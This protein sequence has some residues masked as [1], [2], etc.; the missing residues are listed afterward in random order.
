M[1]RVNV[2]MCCVMLLSLNGLQAAN[3]FVSPAG[4]NNNSGSMASPWKTI[5]KGLDIAQPG[6]TIFIRAG[7]YNESVYSQ[8]DGSP[9]ARIVLSSYQ[10]EAVYIDGTGTGANNGVNITHSYYTLQ[11]L[12]IRDW[13][14]TG[15]WIYGNIG[16][17]SVLN[18]RVHDCPYCLSL[19]D[20]THDFVVGGCEMY[21]FGPASG[22]GDGFGFSCEPNGIPCYNGL[23][24][25]CK[26]YHGRSIAANNDGFALGHQDV[27]NITFFK[28]E[29][30]DV[31][32]G[33]DVSGHNILLDRCSAHDITNGDGAYKLWPD[34]ITMVNCIGYHS[35]SIMQ[36]DYDGRNAV[37][38]VYNCTFHDATGGGYN[39]WIENSNTSRLNLFNC[40]VSGGDNRGLVF[41]QNN[42]SNYNGDYNIFQN[43]DTA[44]V[45]STNTIDLSPA[46]IQAGQWT[47]MT[48][49]Q[50]SHSIVLV[51]SASVFINDNGIAPDLHLKSGS[52]AIN[53]GLLSSAP[54][55]DYSGCLRD[56]GFPDIG[57]FEFNCTPSQ[58]LWMPSSSPIR[59]YPNPANDYIRIN[60]DIL[61]NTLLEIYTLTGEKVRSQALSPG[62]GETEIGLPRLITGIYRVC[63]RS[64]QN[65]YQQK[66]IVQ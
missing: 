2:F 48:G 22:G 60:G 27:S 63:V 43:D 54:S 46:Q 66:L 65:L 26:S 16:F 15:L 61:A 52:P 24:T 51:G 28:C 18:C 9:N 8:R 23:I 17:F 39:I 53:A 47:T 14:D 20:G 59:I 6:D 1:E 7:E 4:N 12:D 13:T 19:S 49:G 34:S 55:N 32:D 36:L 33:F 42:F 38:N 40:I 58:G 41:E 25:N 35:G 64:S 21:N 3:Y 11:K 62:L 31:F 57:A 50:D 30:Y 29:T 10:N 45:I 44:R 37:A 5:Q 56:D